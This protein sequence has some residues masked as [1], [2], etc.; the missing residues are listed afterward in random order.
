MAIALNDELK[1]DVSTAAMALLRA[2][3]TSA[4]L[5]VDSK[6]RSKFLLVRAPLRLLGAEAEHVRL[7]KKRKS[8][9]KLQEFDLGAASAFEHW[10]KPGFF[11]PCEEAELLESLV[12]G[13][14]AASN[15]SGLAAIV[16]NT[17]AGSTKVCMRDMLPTNN[18]QKPPVTPESPITYPSLH[19]HALS[20][21]ARGR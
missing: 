16:S 1:E 19:P 4:G 12:N 18:N 20:I 6:L 3:L 15:P 10:G 21:H 8:D 5:R 13:V 2:Q 11:L 9:G 14:T 7:P 17:A